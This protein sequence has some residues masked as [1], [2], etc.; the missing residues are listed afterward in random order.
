ME[1]AV[2]IPVDYYYFCLGGNDIK[3][4]WIWCIFIWTFEICNTVDAIGQCIFPTEKKVY[5]IH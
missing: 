3:G 4:V 5:K 1:E 2:Q